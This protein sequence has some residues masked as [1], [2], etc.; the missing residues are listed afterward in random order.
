MEFSAII[1]GIHGFSF[2]NVVTLFHDML[3]VSPFH[4]SGKLNTKSTIAGYDC[5][6]FFVFYMKRLCRFHRFGT[7]LDCQISKFELWSLNS[8]A[9]H[10][11]IWNLCLVILRKEHCTIDKGINRVLYF[12]QTF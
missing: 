12:D 4:L 6:C 8:C 1:N 7:Q 3:G 10:L 2:S 5:A 11:L 9:S